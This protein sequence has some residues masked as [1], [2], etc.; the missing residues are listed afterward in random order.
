M[1]KKKDNEYWIA[2]EME[3]KELSRQLEE[4]DNQRKK[5]MKRINVLK[6]SL[7][8]HGGYSSDKTN[9]EIY[10]MF[11]KLKKDLTDEELRMYNVE[12]QRAHRKC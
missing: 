9:T 3:V 8:Y 1:N 4:L 5:I 7:R 2:K 6:T 11:G 12:R 10:K